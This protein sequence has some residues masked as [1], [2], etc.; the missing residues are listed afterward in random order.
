LFGI[1][2]GGSLSVLVARNMLQDCTEWAV[3]AN[4]VES[5]GS[6]RNF[7]LA[8]DKLSIAENWIGL[9]AAT[10][11]GILLRDGPSNV[12][13]A[14][15]MFVGTGGAVLGNCL[16]AGTDSALIE[17]NRWNASGRFTCNPVVAGGLQTVVF[18]DI[19]DAI[20]LTSVASAVQSMVSSG[21]AATAGQFVFAR[22]TS[23]GSGYSA[24]TVTVG[25]GGAGAA[26]VA[27][28][29]GGA[30]IG[31]QVTSAGSGYGALGTPIPIAIS[32]DG[33]GATASAISGLALSEERSIRVHCNVPVTFARVGSNPLQENWTLA[34]LA[35]PAFGE[36]DWTV[37]FGTWRAARATP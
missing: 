21:Q 24:A 17:G 6:G 20:M 33:T 30:I 11:S 14:R 5:D 10:M 13:V 37:T 34:D 26:A 35:V 31:I 36:V 16:L 7:G 23:G 9:S 28:I 27:I 22:V 3:V 32:G 29:S 18:P 4:N 15:N 25:G 2:C 8:C 12:L 1:N 19:G